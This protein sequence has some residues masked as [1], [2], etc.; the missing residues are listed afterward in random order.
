MAKPDEPPRYAVV[1]G[2]NRPSIGF[3]AAQ[4]LAAEPHRFRVILAC[5]DEAKGRATSSRLAWR[6]RSSPSW[7]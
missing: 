6:T 1:T 7:W 2:A 3:R 4:L 5:R